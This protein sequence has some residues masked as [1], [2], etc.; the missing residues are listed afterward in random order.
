ML[1]PFQDHKQ[2]VAPF[3]N[4]KVQIIPPSQDDLTTPDVRDIIALKHTSDT[5]GNMSGVYTICVDP[6]IPPSTACMQESTNRRQRKNDEALQKLADKE[7]ITPVTEPTKWVSSLTYP[8]KSDGTIYPCLAPC[9]L[10]KAVVREHYKAQ[11]LDEISQRLSGTT[12]FS[13]C[14][15]KD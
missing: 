15:T 9:D 6:S 2:H 10:N 13:K 12:V 7:N 4:N 1:D 5:T 11:P 8:R 14:Y 3:Q